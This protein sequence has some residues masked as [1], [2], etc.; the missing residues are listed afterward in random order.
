MALF[1]NVVLNSLSWVPHKESHT[2][3]KQMFERNP[4]AII[5][6]PRGMCMQFVEMFRNVRG[7]KGD[8]Y[9]T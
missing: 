5:M 9:E 3:A 6:H 1:L 2:R 7:D 4:S 8:F